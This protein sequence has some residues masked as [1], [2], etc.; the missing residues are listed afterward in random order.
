MRRIPLLI[1]VLF[2][3][4]T[5]SAAAL[6]P[7][8]IT[9]TRVEPAIEAIRGGGGTT[10][11]IRDPAEELV[12]LDKSGQPFLRMNRDGVFERGSDGAFAEVRKE[13]FFYLHDGHVGRAV[14]NKE[15]LPYPWRIEGTYGGKPFVMEGTMIPA[16]TNT[17]GET[18]GSPVRLTMVLLVG[19][20]ALA[21][22]LLV[23]LAF[24]IKAL[25]K[26]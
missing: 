14:L 10:I 3:I 21:M 6:T 22:G 9:V 23:G 7:P 17:N 2:L 25:V 19:V 15:P 13:H 5:A 16:G 4:L 1:L 20:G 24:L 8:K 26:G 18:N 11:E 12:L